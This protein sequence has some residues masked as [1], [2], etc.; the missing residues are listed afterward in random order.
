M[1]ED[2]QGR[3]GDE[4]VLS[5]RQVLSGFVALAALPGCARPGV[6]GRP[7]AASVAQAGVASVTG[8]KPRIM[9][10]HLHASTSEG[11][12]SVRSQL[13]QAAVHGYDVAWFTEHD[14]RRRRLLY[15][16]AYSFVPGEISHGAAWE[17]EKGP[18]E[19]AL[20]RDSGGMQVSSP[21][22]PADPAEPKASLRIRATSAGAD[23]AA[24]T[25]R[26]DA[27][28]GS[29]TNFRSRIAGRLERVDV[30]PIAS[31]PD[32]WGE[33][34]LSLSHHPSTGGRPEGVYGLRYRLRT[35]V[36]HRIV[37]HDGLT[38]VVDVP[39]PTGRWTQVTLDP[40]TDMAD[41]YPDMDARDHSLH[42]IE[43]RG[44]SRRGAPS[45]VC[46]GHLRFE[47]QEG[48]D[49]V[50]VEDDL[51]SRYAEQTPGV[52]GLVGSEISLGPHVN[53]YG[54]EQ[55][56]YDYGR[57]T[58]FGDRPGDD[59]YP[60][61]VDHV[62]AA[63]G[64]AC[65]NHLGV[66]VT[67]LLGQRTAADMIEVGH[68][69]GG[70]GTIEGQLAAWDTLSRNG[71]FLTGNGA[72]DDHSGQ[73]W[74]QRGNRYYTAAWSRGLSQP[75]LLDSLRRGRVY[76]GY[77]G[78][79]DGALDMSLDGTVPMGSVVVG[80]ARTPRLQVSVTRLPDGGAVELVRGD[81]DHAGTA[82]PRPAT[83]VIR[84]LGATDLSRSRDVPLMHPDDSFHRL[85]VR[86]RA[87]SV[88]AYGQPI[89]LLS[90]NPSGGVPD[91]R[92]VG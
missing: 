90:R 75:E 85:Q 19:G 73:S 22:S 3:R 79:F 68:G 66:P 8:L 84:T 6:T 62:H 43:F 5:R 13:H 35:D 12:G 4:P 87:G 45:D 80:R 60:S 57:I 31:G 11:Q 15:R 49:A 17:L 51:V 26:I 77:L 54:G 48:Y 70:P 24:V 53:Q 69:G 16:S 47:E 72:S 23:W 28:G 36:R 18:E 44:V 61:I 81:V 83:T 55:L 92:R 78:S 42:A 71:L 41:I 14:W 56:P 34:R 32:S 39:V 7:Q 37:G 9:A 82:D 74:E 76:V 52:I 58:Q 86:D 10:M 67:A 50:G 30:L 89:W 25:Y 33:V 46:F 20:V 29:R 63:G 88:V 59:A 1:C 64:L 91:R 38:G 65:I 21:V 40:V 2:D 27:R